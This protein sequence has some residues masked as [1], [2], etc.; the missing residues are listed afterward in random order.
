VMQPMLTQSVRLKNKGVGSTFDIESFADSISLI[1]I[2]ESLNRKGNLWPR[3][4]II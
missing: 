4:T 2:C 1:P 3:E